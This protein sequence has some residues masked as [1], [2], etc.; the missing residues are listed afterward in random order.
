MVYSPLSLKP[1]VRRIL[2]EYCVCAHDLMTS[3]IWSD[4]D[5]VFVIVTPST[6]IVV[7]RSIS[8]MIIIDMLLCAFQ[9]E[10]S[11]YEANDP[12]V[13][14]LIFNLDGLLTSFKVSLVILFHLQSCTCSDW[15]GRWTGA[16]SAA[17][18]HKLRMWDQLS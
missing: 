4:A 7:T 2:R 6:F 15:V 17:V 3:Q 16:A 13:Q 18:R 11:D 5:R 12:W 14:N 10:F 9:E 8:A 1:C